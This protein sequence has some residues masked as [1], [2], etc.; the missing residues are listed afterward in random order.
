MGAIE[1]NRTALVIVDPQNDFLSESGVLWDMVGPLVEKN[2]VVGK[3]KDEERLGGRWHTGNRS[4]T[5]VP[6]RRTPGDGRGS[7]VHRQNQ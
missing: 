6:R 1:A 4:R 5:V 7:N 3:L 2:G